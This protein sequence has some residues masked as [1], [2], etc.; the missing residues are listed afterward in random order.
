MEAFFWPRNDEHFDTAGAEDRQTLE[1]KD[2]DSETGKP[3]EDTHFV[4]IFF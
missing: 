4:G 2:S 1:Q 3:I